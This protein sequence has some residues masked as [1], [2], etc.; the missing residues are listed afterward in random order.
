MSEGEANEFSYSVNVHIN[1]EYDIQVDL[2]QLTSKV[3]GYKGFWNHGHVDDN[4]I[5]EM[6]KEKCEERRTDYYGN[7]PIF[8]DG[9]S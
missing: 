2:I 1:Y 4:G 6:T 8:K 5:D 7:T 9:G 3:V